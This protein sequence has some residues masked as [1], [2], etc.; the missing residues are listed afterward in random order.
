MHKDTYITGLLI[1]GT[2]KA[3][4]GESAKEAQ[5]LQGEGMQTG[6]FH[7]LKEYKALG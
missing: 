2:R 4:Q 5:L 7:C 6:G 1:S 3:Q